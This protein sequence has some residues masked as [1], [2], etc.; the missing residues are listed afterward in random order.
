MKFFFDF[1]ILIGQYFDKSE[2]SLEI[3]PIT[4]NFHYRDI[5]IFPTKSFIQYSLVVFKYCKQSSVDTDNHG[6]GHLCPPMSA[7]IPFWP[8]WLPSDVPKT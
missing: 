8:N 4:Q 3:I 7:P 5:F 2:R 6:R 1:K